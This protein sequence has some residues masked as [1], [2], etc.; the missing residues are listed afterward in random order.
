MDIK[1]LVD[2]GYLV[3]LE[4]KNY[5][6]EKKPTKINNKIV[7]K[8]CFETIESIIEF[9]ENDLKSKEWKVIVRYNRGLGVEYK[10]LKTIEAPSLED[11]KI[12]AK[13]EAENVLGDHIIEIKVTENF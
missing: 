7:E 6:L 3:Y 13:K 4:N 9:I 5:I 10:T 2:N 1:Q 11:A 12:Q 8:K